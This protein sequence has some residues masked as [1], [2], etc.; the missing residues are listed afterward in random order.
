MRMRMHQYRINEIVNACMCI[1]A[2]VCVSVFGVVCESVRNMQLY[3]RI[4]LPIMMRMRM[5]MRFR[6][7]MRILCYGRTSQQQLQHQHLNMC[8]RNFIR[9]NLKQ[10]APGHRAKTKL[11]TLL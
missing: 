9:R 2:C 4:I 6:V 11:R 5:R 10:H 1:C 8:A 7:S 3:V